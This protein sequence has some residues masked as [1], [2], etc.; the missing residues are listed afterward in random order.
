[1]ATA[2][3]QY[4]YAAGVFPAGTTVAQAAREL[5]AGGAVTAG[6]G[7]AR[8]VRRIEVRR[9]L[10]PGRYVTAVRLAA[11]ANPDRVTTLVGRPFAVGTGTAGLRVV[12]AGRLDAVLEAPIT[13]RTALRELKTVAT[14]PAASCS[15]GCVV[16]ADL[17]P[18]DRAG[19]GARGKA[20][21]ALRATV[22][23][24]PGEPGRPRLRIGGIRAGT[25]RLT[26][27]ITSGRR[28]ATATVPRML[29]SPAGRVLTAP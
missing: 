7:R 3:E 14:L 20:Q 8:F 6:A 21:R 11:W 28:T 24:P 10:L 2:D 9:P 18:I 15:G 1:V 12:S 27:T 17:A 23:L 13:F 25:Y 5:A 19:A 16:R 29:L 22:R 4:T 26:I